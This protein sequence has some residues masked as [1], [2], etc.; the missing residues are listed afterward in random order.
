MQFLNLINCLFNWYW[1]Y[2]GTLTWKE[3]FLF[4]VMALAFI[5]ML[6]LFYKRISN[7]TEYLSSQINLPIYNSKD[8]FSQETVGDS[9]F[10]LIEKT[11]SIWTKII[12]YGL[13][14]LI[15]TT[16]MSKLLGISYF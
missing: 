2:T 13:A 4:I 1:W 12:V 9:N 8:V 10:V 16:S 5:K 15:M 3:L 11:T 7:E 14:I 6:L